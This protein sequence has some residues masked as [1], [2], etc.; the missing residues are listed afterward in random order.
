MS[1]LIVWGSVGIAFA[2]LSESYVTRI[3]EDANKKIN[4]PNCPPA[5][6]ASA[7]T[8]RAPQFDGRVK[9]YP[10]QE[11]FPEYESTD[12][13]AAAFIDFARTYFKQQFIEY[14]AEIVKTPQGHY[15]FK[16]V[17]SGTPSSCPSRAKEKDVAA[18]VHTHPQD[19]DNRKNLNSIFQVFSA[20]DVEA[21]EWKDKAIVYLGAP[22]GHILRYDP[23]TSQCRGNT[24]MNPYKIVRPPDK[25]THGKLVIGPRDF[26][27]FENGRK[28]S[29][30]P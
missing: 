29:Y 3:V 2:Q 13:A 27:P 5:V 18:I 8:L 9:S 15:T 26:V 12:K 1:F 17:V 4:K 21:A 16:E 30:C 10:L 11:P 19:P 24:V 22:G 28:P 7:I 20:G 25:G 6:G 14:C 23:G